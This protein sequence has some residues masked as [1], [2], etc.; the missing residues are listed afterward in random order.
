MM[1]KKWTGYIILFCCMETV[2]GKLCTYYETGDD[3][4]TRTKFCDIDC[5]SDIYSSLCC[6]KPTTTSSGSDDGFRIDI[7][8]LACVVAVILLVLT[9]ICC[10]CCCFKKSRGQQGHVIQPAPTVTVHWIQVPTVAPNENIS[11]SYQQ[12]SPMNA[13]G[14]ETQPAQESP[15]LC[16]QASELN[17]NR[18][19]NTTTP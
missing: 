10:C 2:P 19:E 7:I 15:N 6:D 12:I 1:I 16:K 8:T 18:K 9:A 3:F 14:Q 4:I 5:C 13:I 11:E 17:G